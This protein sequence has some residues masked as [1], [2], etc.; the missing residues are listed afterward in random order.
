MTGTFRFLLEKLFLDF[1]AFY[2]R[3]GSE[4][5][6]L[7]DHIRL[8]NKDVLKLKNMSAINRL[9]TDDRVRTSFWADIGLPPS[10]NFPDHGNSELLYGS[11]SESIHHPTWNV[12]YIPSSFPMEKQ[13]FYKTVGHLYKLKVEV[14]DV[15]L[16]AAGKD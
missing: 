3:P 9:L 12:V 14:L 10:L 16:V 8:L 13:M 15:N 11:L 4:T 1:L 5:A 7:K 6:K 2:Q